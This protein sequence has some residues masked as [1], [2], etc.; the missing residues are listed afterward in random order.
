[1]QLLTSEQS[2][3]DPY[4]VSSDLVFI[5]PKLLLSHPPGKEK[6]RDRLQRIQET[7]QRAC[8]GE[9]NDLIR[10][11]LECP[12]PKYEQEESQPLAT[13][14]RLQSSLLAHNYVI[15]FCVCVFLLTVGA[16]FAYNW[17]F[18]L[19][20]GTFLLTVEKGV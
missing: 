6:A 15:F 13:S 12:L 9:W 17:R 2:R 19:T 20:V 10:R 7:F 5:L 1:M 14:P 16:F 18:L 11:T 4:P 3:T 8:Q